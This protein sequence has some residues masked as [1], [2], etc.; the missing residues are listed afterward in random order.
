KGAGIKD[1]LTAQNCA[2]LVRHAQK[3]ADPLAGE[4]ANPIPPRQEELEALGTAQVTQQ[5]PMDGANGAAAESEAVALAFL[6][7]TEKEEEQKANK[8]QKPQQQQQQEA[9]RAEELAVIQ[10]ALEKTWSA[11]GGGRLQI[12]RWAY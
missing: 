7:K 3:S 12:Y 1:G 10:C 2:R 5:A 11:T 6:K 4:K 9:A 8:A